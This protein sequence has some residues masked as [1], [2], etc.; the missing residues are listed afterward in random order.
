MKGTQGSLQHC[1]RNCLLT[2][3]YRSRRRNKNEAN[4]ISKPTKT[5]KIIVINDVH[6]PHQNTRMINNLVKL[7]EDEQPDEII[8]NGDMVDFYDLSSFD[9]D[10]NRTQNLQQELDILYQM[11]LVFRAAC[12]EA[13]IVYIEGNHEDRLKRYLW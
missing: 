2:E 11:L 3:R 9:K 6:V 8:L 5:K 7:I 12:P 13:K 10:P 1:D 4:R